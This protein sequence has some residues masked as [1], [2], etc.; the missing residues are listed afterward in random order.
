VAILAGAV[1]GAV[2]LGFGAT[3]ATGLLRNA[4]PTPSPTPTP[5]QSE[6]IT[7]T[8]EPTVSPSPTPVPTPIP[9]PTPTPIPTPEP[10]APPKAGSPSAPRSLAA[11]GSIGKIALS[12][13]APTSD[14]GSPVTRYDIYKDGARSPF[15]KTTARSYTDNVGNGAIHVYRVTAV[16]AV[17]SSAYSNAATGTTPSVPGVPGNPQAVGGVGQIVL[18]WIAPSN[19]GSPIIRYDIYI[20]SAVTP[21]STGASPYIHAGLAAGS[22]HTYT[23]KAVNAAG[24]GTSSAP[25]VATTANVPGAP[26]NLSATAGAGQIVLTWSAPGNGGS[27]ITGYDISYQGGGIVAN[28]VTALTYTDSVLAAGTL[29]RYVVKAVN[30]VGSSAG[31]SAQASTWSLP[32]PPTGVTASGGNHQIVVSWTAPISDGGTG[33]TLYSVYD[34]LSSLACTTSGLSCPDSVGNGVTHSYTVR[35]TNALGQGASS[36]SSNSATSWDL[37]DAPTLDSATLNGADVDLSWSAP[38]ANGGSSVTGYRIYRDGAEV[39]VVGNVTIWTDPSPPSGLHTYTVA[40]ITAV[41]T[42]PQSNGLD[43]TVP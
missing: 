28:G 35:A 31:A 25:A 34:N 27:P 13:S 6:F 19:G 21:V 7:R 14:G 16:N 15:I 33:I 5:G 11:A 42:S 41:G 39:D 36:T 4:R 26:G 43:A 32:G 29:Y 24:S 17:G 3:Q 23:V 1:L 22:S 30:A 8:P 12:W 20:D 38:A 2:I 37:P 40:A 10:T 9:T 18:T